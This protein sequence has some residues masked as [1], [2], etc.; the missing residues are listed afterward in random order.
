MSHID[1]EMTLQSVISSEMIRPLSWPCT[2][3][4]EFVLSVGYSDGFP[5]WKNGELGV[6]SLFSKD[7]AKPQTET[8]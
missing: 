4:P 6:M 7:E 1:L 5:D 8:G 3:Y 2:V